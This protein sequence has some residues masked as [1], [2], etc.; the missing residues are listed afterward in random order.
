[1]SN[2]C[3]TEFTQVSHFHLYIFQDHGLMQEENLDILGLKA[4]EDVHG[5]D[6]ESEACKEQKKGKNKQAEG[7]VAGTF[8]K[9]R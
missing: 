2:E 7:F 1:M 6:R 4:E 8:V 3:S 9:T 5:N